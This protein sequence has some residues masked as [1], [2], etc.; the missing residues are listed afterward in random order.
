MMTIPETALNALLPS[1]G[2]PTPVAGRADIV[3]VEDNRGT[4]FVKRWP[5]GTKPERVAFVHR[6]LVFA[7]ERGISFVPR[8]A[9]D[10]VTVSGQIFDAFSAL[11]GRPAMRGSNLFDGDG[12]LINRPSVSSPA[13]ATAALRG[14]AQFHAATRD[15]AADPQAPQASLETIVRVIASHWERQRA[16]LRPIAAQ[17][18]HIQRWIRTSETVVQ[19]AMEHFD[20]FG[21]LDRF[22]R[23][24]GHLNLWPA[25][26]LFTQE[27]DGVALTGLLDFEQAAVTTPLLDLAQLVTHFNG[28]SAAQ[29]EDALGLYSEFNPLSPEERRLLPVLAGLELVNEAGRL[30]TLGYA[31]PGL[32]RA[33]GGDALRASAA[34][35]LFSLE[36]LAP[37]VHRGDEPVAQKARKWVHRPKKPAA[38]SP[39]GDRNK[40]PSGPG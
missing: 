2:E 35:L 5:K 22:P 14:I 29:A 21:Y 15:L 6:L 23:V 30:M 3:S 38:Q 33:H 25:H 4:W 19:S 10:P 17:T 7:R 28:W 12:R 31:T 40:R 32:S 39:A 34:T 24:V 20:R 1:A 26:L 36:A 13:H 37:A 9:G 18:P 11:P 16:A 8:L 27:E